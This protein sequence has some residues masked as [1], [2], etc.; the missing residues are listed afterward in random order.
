[1]MIY[2]DSQI[3]HNTA[4]HQRYEHIAEHMVQNAEI[5]SN[6]HGQNTPIWKI[7]IFY[8]LESCACITVALFLNWGNC[9]PTAALFFKWVIQFVALNITLPFSVALFGLL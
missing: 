6:N 7:L 3:I 5:H 1:M 8:W 2:D 4:E 9:I